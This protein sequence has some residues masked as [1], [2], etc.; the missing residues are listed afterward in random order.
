MTEA[1][2][3]H[4]IWDYHL[5]HHKLEK[6][7]VMAVLGSH[8]LRVAEWAAELYRQGWAPRIVVSGSARPWA[9]KLWGMSEAAKFKQVMVEHGVPADKVWTDERAENS[10]ENA[11]YIDEILREHDLDPQLVLCVQKPYMERRTYATLK[12]W[13]PKRK[14]IV[15]SPPI[16]VED[17][18]DGSELS[19]KETIDLIVGDLWRIKEYPAKGFQ[20]PQDIPNDVWVAH[21][22][23]A[24]RGYGW[25]ERPGPKTRPP[26]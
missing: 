3:V 2:A 19:R 14:L 1:E 8:D 18:I 9:L 7:S 23:L 15:S 16:D 12:R 25:P 20:I 17:W 5:L 4:I 10:G 21:D 24:A 22:F 11:K 13:W 26:A 6:A